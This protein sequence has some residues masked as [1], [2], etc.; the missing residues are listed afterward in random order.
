VARGPAG[1][2]RAPHLAAAPPAD[3]AGQDQAL[4]KDSEAHRLAQRQKQIDY[5]KNTVGYQNYLAAVPKE[6]R[7]RFTHPSTPDIH[8]QIGK[9]QWDGLVRRRP[10]ACPAWRPAC[11]AALAAQPSA[12]ASVRA[13]AALHHT[14]AGLLARTPQ[15]KAWRRKLHAW[16]TSEG[17]QAVPLAEPAA[18]APAAP[19]ARGSGGGGGGGG[20][21]DSGSGGGGGGGRDSGSG[22]RQQRP[23]DG[24][25]K[26]RAPKAQAQARGQQGGRQGSGAGARKGAP[27]PAPAAADAAT[28]PPRGPASQSGSQAS[29]KKRGFESAFDTASSGQGRSQRRGGGGGDKQRPGSAASGGSGLGSPW[30]QVKEV[31]AAAG[32]DDDDW[33]NVL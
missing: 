9:R 28:R 15:V 30:E 23:R 2:A 29:G 16:D 10:T 6:Q 27:A 25:P 13:C 33:Q 5:G 3:V 18:A 20:G 7:E 4:D 31:A 12:H 8:V 14:A 26:E 32:S 19:A 1:D 22:G 17:Q 24:A 11:I 21:R